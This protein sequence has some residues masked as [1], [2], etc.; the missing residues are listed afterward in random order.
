[1]TSNTSAFSGWL[2]DFFAAYYRRRPV[3]ATFIGVHD[4]DHQLPDFSEKG[5]AETVE[6]MKGLLAR[7]DTLP[8]ESLTTAETLDRKLAA[9]YLRIQ[10]WEFQSQHFHRGNPCLYTGEAVFSVI[11]LFL[12][13][14]APVAGR[15]AAAIDRMD[16]IPVLLA[17]GQ[18]NLH[19]APAAWIDLAVD[20]CAGARAF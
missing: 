11:S 19:E 8:A 3:N 9:G 1:M 16:A 5:V 6:E 20:E 13:D 7:L 14:Y 12:T 2:D 17:Q 18:A 15:V 4:L 10:L